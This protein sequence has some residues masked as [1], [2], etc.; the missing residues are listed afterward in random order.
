MLMSMATDSCRTRTLE[1]L[2]S[3]QREYWAR[4]VVIIFREVVLL[5]WTL[6]LQVLVCAAENGLD[7][8]VTRGVAYVS[9]SSAHWRWN[10]SLCSSEA[11]GQFR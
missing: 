10:S 6:A 9:S 5:A 3:L 7:G 4:E 11:A 2:L 8:V 1:V